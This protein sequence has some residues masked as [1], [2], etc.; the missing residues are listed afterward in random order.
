MQL[1]YKSRQLPA[2][3]QP[4]RSRDARDMG[5]LRTRAM[6]SILFY[7]LRL[8]LKWMPREGVQTSS[9][10]RQCTRTCC[11]AVW[12]ISLRL[13]F[14]CLRL[15]LIW[16]LG[17]GDQTASGCSQCTATCCFAVWLASLR[18][19]FYCLRLPLKWMLGEGIQT[20]SGC[21]QCTATCCFAVWLASLCLVIVSGCHWNNC[22]G[23]A[24]P[25]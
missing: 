19:L 20:A 2:K 12:L 8:Q 25:K 15:P 23:R 13:L 11:F 4:N 18:L 1:G 5:W 3:L 10:C 14:Y 16:M 24:G 17:E 21:R 22:S 7:C 6:L 9:G